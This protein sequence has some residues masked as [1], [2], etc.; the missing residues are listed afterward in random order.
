[1][2]PRQQALLFETLADLI[3]NGFA[4]QTAFKF[5]VTVHGPQFQ[6]LQPVLDQLAAGESLAQALQDYV[7]LD[8]YYQ[9]LIA[10]L[11]G[12]LTAT[13]TQAG[14]LMRTRTVQAQ[15]VRR[16]LQYPC[17]LL[18]LLIGTLVLVKTTVLPNFQG[19]VQ[20]PA[21]SMVGAL[22]I[23]SS[24]L[25]IGCGTL[26]I[27][28]RLKRMPIRE[29]Y[30]WL[31]RWPVIGPLVREYCG[32]YLAL[33]AGMLLAGGLGIR[34][35]CEVCTHFRDQSLLRQ[36]GAAV[37]QALLAGRT[38]P[39]IIRADSL[40]PNELALLIAKESPPQQLSQELIYFAGIQY[41]RLVRD[42][43]RLISWIQPA[44]FIV[45]AGIIVG[46]Y[47]AILLPMYNSMGAF[48]K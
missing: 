46:T 47:M 21:Q 8:L 6:R 48:S 40:L 14:R 16:L 35:I 28:R 36:E 3:N 19:T 30:R 37:E 29:R 20:P 13:L 43:N 1:M 41:Q 24:T 5:I 4:L 25:V 32:Y 7:A 33:N 38:L 45:I 18:G 34:A 15:R 22:L 31:G 9:L 2:T 11:H 23:S 27:A 26:I 44:M 10:E 12:E 42:L 39:A 17:V